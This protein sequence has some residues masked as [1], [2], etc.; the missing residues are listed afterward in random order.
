M[1]KKHPPMTPAEVSKML[2]NDGWTGRKGKGDHVNFSKTGH[3]FVVTV[4]MG[5]REIPTGTLRNIFR[6]AGWNW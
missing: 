2:E 5:A 1:P 4:D 3:R 6:A